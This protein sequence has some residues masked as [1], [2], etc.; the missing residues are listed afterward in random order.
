[1][2]CTEY[3]TL[4][5]H[6]NTDGALS[7]D[8]LS[9]RTVARSGIFTPFPPRRQA[10]VYPRVARKSAR[11]SLHCV[12]IFFFFFPILG[13]WLNNFL[14]YTRSSFRASQSTLVSFISEPGSKKFIQVCVHSQ[15]ERAAR[16]LH[17]LCY[18][19]PCQEVVPLAAVAPLEIFGCRALSEAH[20]SKRVISEKGFVREKMAGLSSGYPTFEGKVWSKQRERERERGNSSLL[21]GFSK[22]GPLRQSPR[23][24]RSI[25]R[26]A[27]FPFPVSVSTRGRLS[28]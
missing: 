22:H 24:D 17:A 18:F 13:A 7:T 6:D 5:S 9:P 23:G 11:S 14:I 25:S 4:S 10:R 19:L 16:V 15:S 27:I 21:P 28:Q 20:K 1:M 12:T 26:K 3:Y 8:S 2:E